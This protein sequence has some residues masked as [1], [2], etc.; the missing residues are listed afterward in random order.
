MN[1]NTITTP[2]SSQ[3]TG[4]L[5]LFELVLNANQEQQVK[6]YAYTIEIGLV[7]YPAASKTSI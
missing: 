5:G 1:L 6:S 3:N 2:N 7:N 4:Q